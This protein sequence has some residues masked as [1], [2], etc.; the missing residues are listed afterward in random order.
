[1]KDYSYGKLMG[2][3]GTVNNPAKETMPEF[4]YADVA[5]L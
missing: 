4:S 5:M 3:L 1:M 2:L